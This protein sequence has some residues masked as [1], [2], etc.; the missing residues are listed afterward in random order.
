MNN[1]K[2]LKQAFAEALCISV[3]EVNEDLSYQGI[4][5]WDSVSHL[6]LVKE[7]EATFGLTIAID[8]ILE[9]T[10]FTNVKQVLGRFNITFN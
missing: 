5:E 4:A 2:K 6:F 1:L 10:S 3:D 7:I 9:M 8:D